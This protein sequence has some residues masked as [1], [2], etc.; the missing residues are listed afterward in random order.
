MAVVEEV[1][2]GVLTAA[3]GITA[4]VPTYK[5]KVGFV[6]QKIAL[7][8]IAHFPITTTT[9]HV[10]GALMAS[11]S[12][13]YQVSCFADKYSSCK[14]IAEAI[15]TEMGQ[16]LSSGV[17]MFWRDETNTHFDDVD[18]NG[19]KIGVYHIALDFDVSEAL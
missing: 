18:P 1:I 4:L 6:G 19:D 9:E 2:Q 17:T 5:I 3:A 16:K 15:K 10:H 7:P 11:K 8:Y 12:W 13:G 14:A